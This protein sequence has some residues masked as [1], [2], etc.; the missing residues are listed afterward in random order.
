MNLLLFFAALA[1]I[2]L[3]I[4]D[5]ASAHVSYKRIRSATGKVTYNNTTFLIDPTLAKK[6]RYEGFA[7]TFNS[8]VRNPA[9]E[10]PESREQVMADVDAVVLTHT[11]LD[12]WD[13]VAQQFIR[14]DIPFFVQDEADAAAVRGAG[15]SDVR[16]LNVSAVFGASL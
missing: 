14:K 10:L 4:S 12:H 1:V 13:D 9:V 11:H 7:A 16:V 6:G 2:L 8:E 15:F 3:L 5:T